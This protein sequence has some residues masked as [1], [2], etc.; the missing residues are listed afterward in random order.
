M[1]LK[2]HIHFLLN[3]NEI[4]INI[5]INSAARKNEFFRTFGSTGTKDFEK[6]NIGFEKTN[7]GF[8]KTN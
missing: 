8:E 1:V 4:Y 2:E 7:I 6:T 3:Y 5:Y